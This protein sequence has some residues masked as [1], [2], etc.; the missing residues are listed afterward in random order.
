MRETD[1]E[2]AVTT[3][4]TFLEGGNAK[5]FQF[6][7]G[8]L[9]VSTCIVNRGRLVSGI[10]SLGKLG[11]RLEVHVCENGWRLQNLSKRS[12]EDE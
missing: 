10:G 4:I 3:G 5:A 1:L 11:A 9:E 7:E 2:P 8:H 12:R 6:A